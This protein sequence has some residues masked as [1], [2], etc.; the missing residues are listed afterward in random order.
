MV[1]LVAFSGTL[2][3]FG[4]VVYTASLP[5]L[6]ANSERV[7]DA[8]DAATDAVERVTGSGD[9]AGEEKAADASSRATSK[10]ATVTGGKV[11]AAG[12]SPKGAAAAVSSKAEDADKDKDKDADKAGEAGD[13]DADQDAFPDDPSAPEPAPSPE[14]EPDP[15]PEPSGPSEGEEQDVYNYLLPIWQR[16]D[17]YVS[18]INACIESFNN[19]SA[20]ASLETR[21]QHQRVCAKVNQS[22]L[23]ERLTLGS[24]VMPDGSRYTSALG[25]LTGMYRCLNEWLGTIENAWVINVTFDDPAAHVDEYMAPVYAATDAS[26]TNVHFAEFRTYYEGFAL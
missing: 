16:V 7:A 4:T 13:G 23:Q 12:I 18:Q 22:I 15:A 17:G 5:A 25:N 19:D 8:V 14:P 6:I 20:T 2:M 10:R 11:G 24:C 9:G 1:G 3:A 26:G 21:L